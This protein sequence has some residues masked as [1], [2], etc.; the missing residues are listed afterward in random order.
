MFLVCRYGTHSLAAVR[1]VLRWFARASH[2]DA[3]DARDMASWDHGGGFS[4]DASIRVEGPDR[5]G[6]ERLL[7]KA[8]AQVYAICFAEPTNAVRQLYI[9]GTLSWR[10][11]LKRQAPEGK[12]TLP[13]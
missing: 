9:C 4:L 11:Q 7:P 12:C 13:A 10:I 8:A 5:A 2:L 3:A 6:L 1:R